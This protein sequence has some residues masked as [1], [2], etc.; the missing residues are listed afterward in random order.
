[1]T[2]MPF[3]A[4]L[5]ATATLAALPVAAAACSRS[6]MGDAV[7]KDVTVQ[8]QTTQDPIAACYKAALERNRKLR[9]RMILSFTAE[10]GTGKFTGVQVTRDDLQDEGL[11]TCVVERVS[12]LALKS[13]QKSAV[14]VTYPLDFAPVK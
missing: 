2:R 8:M 9:G 6:G 3:V 12:S 1:M 10:P 14:A 4:R 11:R 5:L 13:P 7:R